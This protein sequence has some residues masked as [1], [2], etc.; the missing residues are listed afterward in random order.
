MNIASRIINPD[1]SLPALL[2]T[3]SK[4]GYLGVR[5]STILS[6]T[7]QATPIVTGT[8]ILVMSALA[9]HHQNNYNAIWRQ[10]K[11]AIMKSVVVYG[12]ASASIS[13]GRVN[14][15]AAV[16]EALRGVTAKQGR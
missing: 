3:A 9:P 16:E 6:G 5:G 15:R 13:G 10:V 2:F 1:Y 7:S 11:S 8:A 12:S 14:A 4:T